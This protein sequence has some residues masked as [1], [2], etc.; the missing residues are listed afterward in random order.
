MPYEALALPDRANLSATKAPATA[1]AAYD[2]IRPRHTVRD[3]TDRA[4]P[5]EAIEA[6]VKAAGSAPSGA[7]RQPWPVVAI[8]NPALKKPARD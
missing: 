8:S 3:F 5:R 1:N 4:I 7:N 2:D 6:C